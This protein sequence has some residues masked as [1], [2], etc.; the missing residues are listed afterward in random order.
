MNILMPIEKM[1]EFVI[2]KKL[3]EKL[4][5]ELLKENN[6]VSEEEVTI[7]FPKHIKFIGSSVV[8]RQLALMS[9]KYPNT[10][11]RIIGNE[12]VVNMFQRFIGEENS[13]MNQFSTGKE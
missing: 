12:A 13:Y 10:K 2:D 1:T 9:K 11:F 4:L 8:T 6:V 7:E 3:N 5:D